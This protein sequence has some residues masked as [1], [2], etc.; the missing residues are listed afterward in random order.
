MFAFGSSCQPPLFGI[1]KFQA[2]GTTDQL[3]VPD[4]KSILGSFAY[5]FLLIIWLRT[6]QIRD[7]SVW[8]HQGNG[9]AKHSFTDVLRHTVQYL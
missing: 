9:L 8:M 3:I 2:L 1:E 5:G 6:E 7:G 4:A